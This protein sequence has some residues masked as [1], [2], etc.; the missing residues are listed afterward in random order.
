MM[1]KMV[2]GKRV[3]GSS[4]GGLGDDENGGGSRGSKGGDVDKY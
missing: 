2:D 1:V 3:E 4:R